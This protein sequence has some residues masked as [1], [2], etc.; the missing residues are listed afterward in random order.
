ML[1]YGTT[2]S[3]SVSRNGTTAP[4]GTLTTKGL[5]II[6]ERYEYFDGTIWEALSQFSDITLNTSH[7]IR[8]TVLTDEF[9]PFTTGTELPNA[10]FE[11]I[12]S[13]SDP[14]R[15]RFH[16]KYLG[17]VGDGSS[18]GITMDITPADG[19]PQTDPTKINIT[20][21]ETIT[22]RYQYGTQM[23]VR[24]TT[25]N[26]PVTAMKLLE[27]DWTT[28]IDTHN[29]GNTSPFYFEYETTGAVVGAS[30]KINIRCLDTGKVIERYAFANTS[31]TYR[32][33]IMPADINYFYTTTVNPVG[34][35]RPIRIS[36]SVADQ[37]VNPA[38]PAHA[39]LL[40][41][42]FIWWGYPGYAPTHNPTTATFNTANVNL[43]QN[44]WT[45]AVNGNGN[46]WVR[47]T[48]T[49]DPVGFIYR[50]S[51]AAMSNVA[52]Q[53]KLG[54]ETDPTT[55]TIAAGFA[56]G[57]SLGHVY[58]TTYIADVP[59]ATPLATVNI[60]PQAYRPFF[61][62]TPANLSV[63][64]DVYPR[65]SWTPA[66]DPERGVGDMTHY[67]V[68][69]GKNPFL[70]ITD[71]TTQVYFTT[72]T[73]FYP[74]VDLEFYD[75]STGEGI[76]F[77]RVDVQPGGI[78][79]EAAN[80]DAF[81]AWMLT[82]VPRAGYVINQPISGDR[83]FSTGGVYT[84][85]HNP[86]IAAG[87]S[88][89]IPDGTTVQFPEGSNLTVHGNLIVDGDSGVSGVTFE[90][91]TG[92]SQ[93]D[94]IIFANDSTSPLVVDDIHQYVSGPLLRGLTV[95]DAVNPIVT[96]PGVQYDI[97][98]QD[99]EFIY[100]DKGIVISDGSYVNT[101]EINSFTGPAN[102]LVGDAA[103]RGG[104]Y[105][106]AVVIDGSENS[107]SYPAQYNGSGI[108][109]SNPNAIF[110]SNTVTNIGGNALFISSTGA[111]KALFNDNE[112]TN[113]GSIDSHVAIWA[114]SG[115][116]VTNN[117]IG[118]WDRSG[119]QV[120]DTF[121]D[122]PLAI[123]TGLGST[124]ENS[125][126]AGFAIR[127]GA[128]IAGNH[129]AENGNAAITADLGASIMDNWIVDNT[130]AA[131]TGG[132]IIRNNII[133]NVSDAEAIGTD[134]VSER[135]R[136]INAITTAHPAAVIASNSITNSGG[137][138]IDGGMEVFG[139]NIAIVGSLPLSTDTGE[140][141]AIKA[142]LG[143]KVID[144]NITLP[145]GYGIRHGSQIVNNTITAAGSYGIY[146][147]AGATVTDNVITGAGGRAIENGIQILRN[148]ISGTSDAI[149]ADP[150]ADVSFND[151]SG[152]T[153]YAILGGRLINNNKIVG[154]T[155]AATTPSPTRSPA[156]V[157]SS[158][159]VE[160]FIGNI[161]TG[162]TASAGSILNFVKGGTTSLRIEGNTLT[163][164]RY[165]HNTLRASSNELDIFDNT[166]ENDYDS[167]HGTGGGLT[168]TNGVAQGHG[169][170]VFIRLLDANAH[171]QRNK[172]TGHKGDVYGAALYIESVDGTNGPNRMIVIDDNNVIYGNWAIGPHAMGAAVYHQSGTVV[173]GA[174]TVTAP[175]PTNPQLRG[176]TITNNHVVYDPATA[177]SHPTG[178]AI[179]SVPVGAMSIYRNIIASTTGNWAI[180]GNPAEMHRNNIYDNYIDPDDRIQA[181]WTAGDAWEPTG[182]NNHFYYTGLAGTATGSR[183][184]SNF[185]GTRSDMGRIHPSI[186]D[187][188]NDPALGIVTYQP[189]LSGPSPD[190]PGIVSNINNVRVAL[191]IP[192]V[193]DFGGGGVLNVPTDIYLYVV[194][195]ATDNN[196]F[197]QD[198]TATRITNMDNNNIFIQP[199][200]WETGFDDELYVARFMLSSTGVYDPELNILPVTG[201]NTIRLTVPGSNLAPVTLMAALQGATSVYPYVLEYDFGKWAADETYEYPY[202]VDGA[203]AFDPTTDIS[204]P[205]KRFTF[206][207][208]G[209][210]DDYV[211]D[212]ISITGA[213]ADRFQIISLMPGGDPTDIVDP[214]DIIPAIGTKVPVGGSFDV[215]VAFLPD[216]NTGSQFI[217]TD[218]RLELVVTYKGDASDRSSDRSIRLF[219]EAIADWNAVTFT[220]HLGVERVDPFGDPIVLTNQM[221]FVSRVGFDDQA[222]S[223][224][225]GDILLA[226]TLK[227][228]REELRGK[229]YI[230]STDATGG[231]ATIIVHTDRID[232][233]IFFKVWSNER[234]RLYDTPQAANFF[235]IPGATIGIA[236]PAPASSRGATHDL[237][238]P[239]Q[240]YPITGYTRFHIVGQI[241]DENDDPVL[242]AFLVN[243]HGQAEKNPAT[244][245]RFNYITDSSG[246][247]LVPAWFNENIMLTPV[248]KGWTF[249]TGT[250]D[251]D[252]T[253]DF[254]DPVTD[255]VSNDIPFG[256]QAHPSAILA[257]TMYWNHGYDGSG[258]LGSM[259]P[260]TGHNLNAIVNALNDIDV[261]TIQSHIFFDDASDHIAFV[262]TIAKYIIAG[263]LYILEEYDPLAHLTITVNYFLSRADTTA[264]AL[265]ARQV[266]T[267]EF[268]QFYFLMDSEMYLQSLSISPEQ[269][270]AA[271]YSHIERNALTL[272]NLLIPVHEVVDKHILDISL[273]KN[274]TFLR[275]QLIVVNPGWNLISINV[276]LVAP[277]V[278]PENAFGQIE[279]LG[280]GG[281][282]PAGT[283]TISQV[284]HMLTTFD[285][286]T[287]E[288]STLR[289]ILPRRGYLAYF[290]TDAAIEKAVIRVPKGFPARVDSLELLPDNW[291]QIGYS[292][293][294]PTQTRTLLQS[295]PDILQ[296]SSTSEAY[297]VNDDPV[298]AST[299]WLMAPGTGYWVNTADVI[300]AIPDPDDPSPDAN[301]FAA[302]LNYPGYNNVLKRLELGPISLTDAHLSVTLDNDFGGYPLSGEPATHLYPGESYK[303]VG[304][305]PANLSSYKDIHGRMGEIFI[306][307][308]DAVT[309]VPVG[310]E[311]YR[312]GGPKLMEV[313]LPH[314]SFAM[315]ANVPLRAIITDN[316]PFVPQALYHL[317]ST[318]YESLVGLL[319]ERDGWELFLTALGGE[320]NELVDALDG[321]FDLPVEAGELGYLIFA[322]E[323]LDSPANYEQVQ[324]TVYRLR[325]TTVAANTINDLTHIWIK[326]DLMAGAEYHHAVRT[327]EADFTIAIPADAVLA[328]FTDPT[329]GFAITGSAITNVDPSSD[330]FAVSDFIE[331]ED[332]DVEIID[333]VASMSYRFWV[334]NALA[335]GLDI[336]PA[337]FQPYKV[338]V[339]RL[340]VADFDVAGTRSLSRTPR[341]TISTPALL[342]GCTSE[343]MFSVADPFGVPRFKTNSHFLFAR[344][345]NNGNMLPPEGFVVAAYVGD[346]LRS[347]VRIINFQGNSY[348][349]LL[350]QTV[351]QNEAVRFEIWRN[352][353]SSP[354][355]FVDQQGNDVVFYT[356]P[357]GS[358]GNF[359]NPFNLNSSL[360]IISDVDEVDKPY[361]N[362]L[363]PAYPN[364]FNPST[365]IRF[366][367]K[368]AQ[369][370]TVAVYNVKGQRVAT[371]VD[372]V[373]DRGFHT[374]VWHGEN[375]IG[376]QVGSGIYF[377]RMQTDGYS[378]VHKAVL[379]K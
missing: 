193:P 164:N 240:P 76:Y 324:L 203:S 42:D 231:L 58:A 105:F 156:D 187:G 20:S 90:V 271:G 248:K 227:N 245:E 284:R 149:L 8:Y 277:A 1:S 243:M 85:G 21:H 266:T 328:D 293:A 322:N 80:A 95:R 138:G 106:N 217:V 237:Y 246:Y 242:G 320:D 165:A 216:A 175:T 251:A 300:A 213:D 310:V 212:S 374:I 318:A 110:T 160:E 326:N 305:T 154:V 43:T 368:D 101:V 135:Y 355:R 73:Y 40:P 180:Y 302:H 50:H 134:L 379:M 349:P 124:T 301:R 214:A 272:G 89:T 222:A 191:N 131:I 228:M 100:N 223:L 291:N 140:N 195:N 66:F 317:T 81:N 229:Q 79:S 129:I 96:L 141:F 12:S 57:T 47:I 62:E 179:H 41:R 14:D 77:W 99:S 362:E 97:Y 132:G 236:A 104:F 37:V 177:V 15:P 345:S 303:I 337:N 233:E 296:V 91:V 92:G 283:G 259:D 18:F 215:L 205:T 161:I 13:I 375:S 144:N 351:E 19:Q 206:T 27:S 253:D 7:R 371:L 142:L 84:F 93:W 186:F 295:Q 307:L 35:N 332:E 17:R 126:N 183:F 330:G 323:E 220:D 365:N 366:S 314:G 204:Y 151:I 369:H 306:W 52:L 274:D 70:P 48:S 378:K 325:Y 315:P 69:I 125:R 107:F 255:L 146:A 340:P 358:F 285:R 49:V 225:E 342:S 16:L 119:R 357:G 334:R 24:S 350:I 373:L 280:A 166:I 239:G 39:D 178:A 292:P 327:G 319:L 56:P 46:G 4:Q 31:A 133:Q 168:V 182:Q 278:Q 102:H 267:D 6:S 261:G 254:G 167:E 54:V 363:L 359:A 244:S 115:A 184:I 120:I 113:T 264:P 176:N 171:M 232:E 207:N 201:G 29:R 139:N 74:P 209:D 279:Y 38:N 247:F 33:V 224:A 72:N 219:G 86:T 256:V 136:S 44:V 51:G 269:L 218:A 172:I 270:A 249:E 241:I 230:Q 30:K 343:P 55:N 122:P 335:G 25:P 9:E 22:M 289:S 114:N 10:W 63:A 260:V 88:L 211:I 127:N 346:E 338:H 372:E 162:S 347:K 75:P 170:A 250:D 226:Y 152:V 189:I 83:E 263:H 282:I 28:L 34:E 23:T 11:A 3:W 238:V 64:V 377:I 361:I 354:A 103:I 45:T 352:G 252:I 188:I 2:Y 192:S 235:S 336:T 65:F 331:S 273:S 275:E 329:W 163:N 321:S 210:S 94:G 108:I 348:A 145:R 200:C 121:E 137:W 36:F 367:L 370:T 185:W 158:S 5:N 339:V 159:V 67:R 257:G 194:V 130:G 123:F 150:Q 61:L 288:A 311:V 376:R 304:G 128:I 198:F 59:S 196:D 356:I 181:T 117:R 341:M 32:A 353:M 281:V 268:G 111:G 68:I 290:D 221:T 258:A 169:V 173:L 299:L 53:I 190:T 294:K 286:P 71:P 208:G 98:I 197:S 202:N 234:K 157:V 262:G 87:G 344:V 143:A 297:F 148:T 364:P 276:N 312:V 174:A 199:L 265:Q 153:G 82:T 155:T 116:T 147:D 118:N 309:D 26:T 287:A 109:T 333:D 316:E 60:G 313:S 298:G 308:E 112:I 78:N 360:I